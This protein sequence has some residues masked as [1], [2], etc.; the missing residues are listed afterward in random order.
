MLTVERV[1]ATKKAMAEIVKLAAR[2]QLPPEFKLGTPVVVA[3]E[4]ELVSDV[5]ERITTYAPPVTLAVYY[6]DKERLEL[7]TLE[8]GPRPSDRE[9]V[10]R[11]HRASTVGMLVDTGGYIS[12]PGQWDQV[13]KT[14]RLTASPA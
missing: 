2:K 4:D 13:L 6:P 5:M 8:P 1:A 7:I 10:V 11:A 9:E 3:L 12:T 14:H